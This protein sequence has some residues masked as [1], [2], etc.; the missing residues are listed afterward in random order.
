M[1]PARRVGGGSTSSSWRVSATMSEAIGG[2][3]RSRDD[4]GRDERDDDRTVMIR[5]L[6][7]RSESGD[8]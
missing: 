6:S 7:V 4:E 2:P 1:V 5:T 8:R 3:G